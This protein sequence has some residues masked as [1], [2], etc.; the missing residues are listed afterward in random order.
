MDAADLGC[1]VV[2]VGL[3]VTMLAH[4]WN[5]LFG[6]GGLDGTTRWFH[7]VGLRPAKVHATLSGVG[8]IA[9]GLAL[10]ACLL[11]APALMF[12]V[13]AMT[14]AGWAVHAR[15]GFFVFRE[16]YEY[17]LFVAVTA[18]ALALWGPGTASVDHALGIADHLDGYVG[19]GFVGAGFASAVLV[20][21][22]TFRDLSPSSSTT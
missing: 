19:L 10:V 11:T 18:A 5:H 4:G 1:L 17:V 3:G 14:V 15:N 21:A 6:P 2:R 12:V 7:G 13:S 16:G 8:E 22:A 9:A 20:L